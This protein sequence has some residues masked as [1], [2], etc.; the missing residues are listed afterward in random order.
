LL[1]QLLDEIEIQYQKPIEVFGDNVQA[2]RLASENIITP[3]NQYIAHQYHCKKEKFEEG[4]ISIHWIDINLNLADIYTKFLT[5]A[6]CDFLMP[7][8]LGYG[9]RILVFREKIRTMDP[10]RKPRPEQEQSTV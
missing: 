9:K 6:Q 8:L 1:T 3:G 10:N 7:D 2:N 4:L 5:R